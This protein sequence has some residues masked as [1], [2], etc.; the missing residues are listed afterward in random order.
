MYIC[1][2]KIMNNC[3]ILLNAHMYTYM[4]AIVLKVYND[5]NNNTWLITLEGYGVGNASIE[6]VKRVQTKAK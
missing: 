6:A 2:E 5:N 1:E 4:Q 3:N